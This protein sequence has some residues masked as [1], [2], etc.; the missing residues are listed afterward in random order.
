MSSTSVSVAF[1]SDGAEIITR[2]IDTNTSQNKKTQDELEKFYEVDRCLAFI[3]DNGYRKV[4]RCTLEC[5]KYMENI[6]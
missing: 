6:R 5:E 4:H 3:T 2:K 1:S